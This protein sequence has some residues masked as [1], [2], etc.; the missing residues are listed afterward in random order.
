MFYSMGNDYI[1]PRA[2]QAPNDVRNNQK[3]YKQLSEFL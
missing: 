2:T 1:T 3:I